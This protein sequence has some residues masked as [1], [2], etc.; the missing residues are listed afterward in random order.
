MG[1]FTPSPLGRSM[2]RGCM[3]KGCA[4]SQKKID[5]L[6]PKISCCGALSCI[7]LGLPR[8][9]QQVSWSGMAYNNGEI[10]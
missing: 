5:I 1:G 4:P 8:V 10:F 3:E 9:K 2:G 7:I 6:N